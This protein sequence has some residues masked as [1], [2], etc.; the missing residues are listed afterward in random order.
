[1][2]QHFTNCEVTKRFQCGIGIIP[3]FHLRSRDQTP[4]T[5]PEGNEN[6]LEHWQSRKMMIT[7]RQAGGSDNKFKNCN[8]LDLCSTRA[9]AFS[10]APPHPNFSSDGNNNCTA[11]RNAY[12]KHILVLFSEHGESF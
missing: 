1:M 4:T 9:C 8:F 5:F 12:I 6:E 3:T 11:H 10:V 2:V 7:P